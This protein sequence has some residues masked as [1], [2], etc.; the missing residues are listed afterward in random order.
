MSD[1]C[2][3]LEFARGGVI[4]ESSVINSQ[5]VNSTVQASTIT[6]SSIEMLAS[7]DAASAV[8]IAEALAKLSSAQLKSLAEAIHNAHGAVYGAEPVRSSSGEELPT[9]VV[10]Q[11][12]FL[13]GEPDAWEMRK[14]GLCAPVFRSKA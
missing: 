13:L 8:V 9:T 14:D 4:D 5:I 10:G 1:S 2:C 12:T 6:A 7:I 3:S 11:R